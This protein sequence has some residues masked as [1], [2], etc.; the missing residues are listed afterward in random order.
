M[1]TYFDIAVNGEWLSGVHESVMVSDVHENEVR[2]TDA[3]E[4]PVSFGSRF[5]RSARKSLSVTVSFAIAER[6]PQRRMEVLK[7][8]QDWAIA[9]GAVEVSYRDGQRLYAVCDNPPALASANK[10][11]GLLEAVFTACDVPFWIDTAETRAAITKSGSIHPGGSQLTVVC[12]AAIT[13]TG[14]GAISRVEIITDASSV[15][16]D[17]ILLPAGGTLNITHNEKWVLAAKIAGESVLAKR[18][19]QS[20]DDLYLTGGTKNNISIAAD[21]S[22]SAVFKAR[23]VYL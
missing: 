14:S 21:G 18:T 6:D 19:E 12:D 23:G 7:L 2:Q 20:S 17:G 10:W 9:G 8:V 22:V 16:F 5:V 3:A 1:K 15:V 11:T 13:N 4:K